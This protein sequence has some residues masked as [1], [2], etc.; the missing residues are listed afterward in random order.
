[1]QTESSLFLRR[2][3]H[4]LAAVLHDAGRARLVVLAHGFTGHKGENA[5][6]FVDCAR[7]LAAR[8]ISALRFDFMGSGDSSGNFDEMTPNTEIADLHAV[9][10]WAR[11]QR[12]RRIGVLGL[13]FGGAVSICTVAQRPAGDI[14]ALC[15]WSSV[16]G[17]AFWRATPEPAQLDRQNVSRVGRRFYSDRPKLDVPQAYA[18]LALP[19]LQIQG[20]ADLPGFR[21]RFEEFFPAASAPKRHLVLPGADHVFT[22]AADRRR[23]IAETTRFFA[24]TLGK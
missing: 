22:R 19:K 12:F 14:A 21:E 7:A 6:L 23:V 3:A 13:S 10:D 18:S 1:M 24:R 2:G 5:R 9:L 8:G 17:F 11:T 20:D 16:P 4:R 15:T